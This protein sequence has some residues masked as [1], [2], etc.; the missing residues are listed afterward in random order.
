MFQTSNNQTIVIFPL[1]MGSL[2]ILLA[3]FNRQLLHFINIKPS[4]EV[5]TNPRFQRS[6][7]ITEK[8]A[9]LFLVVFG[10]GFLVQGVGP[11]FLSSEVT[12]IVSMTIL[13]FSA[14][15]ILAAVVVVLANWKDKGSTG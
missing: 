14:L 6:A 3:L 5:F 2:A 8:L 4:S 1:L 10:V 7:K 12:Y 11:Q 13:G 9:Q 15:I